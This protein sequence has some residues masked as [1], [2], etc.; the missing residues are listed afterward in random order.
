MLLGEE[1]AM[2]GWMVEDVS[3]T[4]GSDFWVCEKV[5]SRMEEPSVETCGIEGMQV[6]F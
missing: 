5:S 4:H 3:P 2:S 6:G 1:E